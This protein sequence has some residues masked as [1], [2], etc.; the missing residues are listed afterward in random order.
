MPIKMQPQLELIKTSSP[1]E[2]VKL[3]KIVDKLF[4]LEKE[5]GVS[6]AQSNV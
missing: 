3:V 2:M 4:E 1:A 6:T 5:I